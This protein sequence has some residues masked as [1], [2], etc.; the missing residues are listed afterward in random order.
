MKLII[1]I[2]LFCNIIF[3]QKDFSELEIRNNGN[4]YLKGDSVPFTGNVKGYCKEREK[5]GRMGNAYY[6][7]FMNKYTILYVKGKYYK[8]KM[9]G[10]WVYKSKDGQLLGFQSFKYGIRHGKYVL[11]HSNKMKKI[12]AN[13]VNNKK[14]GLYKAWNKNGELIAEYEYENGIIKK[15]IKDPPYGQ[16]YEIW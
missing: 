8:G 14:D 11:F 6:F 7:M 2:T 3:A 15:T 10:K 4:V 5:S 12:E 9:H 13:Y 1:I 16:G